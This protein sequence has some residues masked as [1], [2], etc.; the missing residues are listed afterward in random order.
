MKIYTDDFFLLSIGYSTY[1]AR[2][3]IGQSVHMSLTTVPKSKMNKKSVKFNGVEYDSYTAL[4]EAHDINYSS[5]NSARTRGLTVKQAIAH[6]KNAT[7]K[8]EY[9]GK[10]YS[11]M[12]EIATAVG[13]NY[14]S[15]SKHIRNGKSLED[16]ISYL[17]KK[18]RALSA[19][20]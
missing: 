19:P 12:M 14:Y 8:I 6:C 4:A 2:R 5:F 1:K 3:N 13:V 17:L 18:Q 7:A 20:L 10:N 16:A 11:T 15:M 9:E